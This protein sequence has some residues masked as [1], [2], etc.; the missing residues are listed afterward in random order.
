MPRRR[1]YIEPSGIL[2][3]EQVE[4]ILETPI[5]EPKNLTPGDRKHIKK[6][7]LPNRPIY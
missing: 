4:E 6:L 3:E 5:Q 7:K 1:S 2:P